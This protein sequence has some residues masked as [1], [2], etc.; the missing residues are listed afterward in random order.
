MGVL[1]LLA[2][3]RFHVE[4]PGAIARVEFRNGRHLPNQLTFNF[5][6]ANCE[7]HQQGLLTIWSDQDFYQFL[8]LKADFVFSHN[9]DGEVEF[10]HL[11]AVFGGYPLLHNVSALSD[12]G[13]CYKGGDID[14]AIGLLRA[15]VLGDPANFDADLRESRR[16]LA[17][18]DVENRDNIAAYNKAL[19][20]I[21]AQVA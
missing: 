3:N 6:A 1:P 7:V 11:D 16:R 13:Y 12:L 5:I 2:V 18:F 9:L 15:M 4:N 20:N 19:L 14:Q 10:D 8:P 21:C 17:R